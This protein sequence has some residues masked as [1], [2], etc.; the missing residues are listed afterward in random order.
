MPSTAFRLNDECRRQLADL[1]EE[2]GMT[3]R[4]IIEL[5][6][7]AEWQ[8]WRYPCRLRRGGRGNPFPGPSVIAQHQQGAFITN[9]KE[10]LETI[11][12]GDSPEDQP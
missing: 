4:Q 11:A 2:T 1:K 3:R 8:A 6:V 12:A 10:R 9:L 7:L 5:L